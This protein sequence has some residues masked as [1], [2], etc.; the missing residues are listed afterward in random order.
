MC[1]NDEE[2]RVGYLPLLSSVLA[3]P[4]FF[5]FFSL[6]SKFQPT[7]RPSCSD[8]QEVPFAR[9]SFKRRILDTSLRVVEVQ[10]RSITLAGY[11]KVKEIANVG[12]GW[13]RT[14]DERSSRAAY[15]STMHTPNFNKIGQNM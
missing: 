6:L 5:M 7:L 14:G 3:V 15:F 10:N 9:T 13:V 2:T 1:D 4:A 11:V 12:L 8:Q